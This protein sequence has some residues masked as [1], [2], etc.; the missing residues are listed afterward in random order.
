MS[1]SLNASVPPPSPVG[2]QVTWTAGVTGASPGTL[3]YRFRSRLA[4]SDFRVIRDYGP[5]SALQWTAS[6]QEGAYEVELAVRNRDTG[7]T[8]QTV[9]PYQVTSRVTG[10]TPVINPT[11]NP[12]VFLYSAPPCPVG[13][14]MSVQF[15][16][17][18]GSVG[19]TPPKPCLADTSMNLYL[20]GL[21]ANSTY[22]VTQ[23][24]QVGAGSTDGPVLSLTSG[25]VPVPVPS[26]T[27]LQP[28]QQPV[29]EGILLQTTIL[30]YQVTLAS[31]LAGN[32]VW[33]YPGTL[34][35]ITRPAP[36]GYFFGVYQ[37][38]AL[39]PSYQIL[40]EFDLAGTTILETNAARVSEQLAVMGKRAITSFH[41]EASL[42]PDGKILTLAS[43]EQV[44]SGIQGT[45]SVDVLGDMLLVLDQNLQV[46]WAWDA[47]DHLDPHRL[48]VLGETCG[49][50]GNR[51]AARQLPSVH[52]RRKH[53]VFDPSPGLGDQDRL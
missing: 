49:R 13:G 43:T 5:E 8:A 15:Q 21:K 14:Q 2:T 53:R 44:M 32:I 18:D 24:L 45:G 12:L 51:L 36:G 42:L 11:A 33:Y 7:E 47:F 39:D 16:A 25:S 31:D 19:R 37:D 50:T 3:W 48:P 46:V 52:A 22:T 34:S 20:A 40:R 4:G 27:V 35:F 30:N 10:D 6:D 38:P 1:V 29:A 41:H 9:V 23:T 26:F 17:P 28:P